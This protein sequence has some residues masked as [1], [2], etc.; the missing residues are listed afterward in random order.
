MDRNTIKINIDY[1][2]HAYS[3]A[4]EQY[5]KEYK[6]ENQNT[7]NDFVKKANFMKYRMK[8]CPDALI[9][10][11]GKK[12][13]IDLGIKFK[14]RIKKADIIC[15]SELR[16]TMETA[17][18]SCKD[19]HKKLYVL[20]YIS[21]IDTNYDNC[22][23]EFNRNH[24]KLYPKKYINRIIKN[25]LLSRI[26]MYEMYPS[27]N[28]FPIIDND[29]LLK[30][31][32]YNNI[33]PSISN[34]NKF[35]SV[36][37]PEICNILFKNSNKKEYNIMIFTHAGFIRNHFG[38]NGCPLGKLDITSDNR[39]TDIN[40]YV[41]KHR[42]PYNTNI[43]TEHIYMKNNKIYHEIAKPCDCIN[44]CSK[45]HQIQLDKQNLNI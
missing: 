35:Y 4:N 23:L 17:S 34:H 45:F 31:D 2:R 44:I 28:A 37:L 32:K 1:I 10:D 20:P 14:E 8:N 21:E 24:M 16:R 5:A 40:K 29:I 12:Q 18:L 30:N 7:L 38:L 27:K 33:K 13:S 9:T 36:V 19:I 43:Y 11:V 26:Y 22:P 41:P 3:Y 39:F 25:R 42:S 15:C 6:Y